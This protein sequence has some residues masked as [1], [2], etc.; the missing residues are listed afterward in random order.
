VNVV[1]VVAVIALDVL[2]T[3][4]DVPVLTTS[5]IVTVSPTENP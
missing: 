5:V 3:V 1:V 4:E 2:K